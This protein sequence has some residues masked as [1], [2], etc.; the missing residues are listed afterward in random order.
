MTTVKA[1]IDLSKLNMSLEQWSRW[2]DTNNVR[3][4]KEASEWPNYIRDLTQGW[5]KI[6]T[7]QQYQAV[8]ASEITGD[9]PGLYAL[10]IDLGSQDLHPI[11]GNRTAYFG[12]TT[13]ALP[14]RLYQHVGALKGYRTNVFD[15]WNKYDKLVNQA[16][17]CDIKNQLSKTWI[18]FRPHAVTDKE[19]KWQ[20][21]HSQEMEKQALAHYHSLWGMFPPANTRD[22]P[23]SYLCEKVDAQ[24]SKTFKVTNR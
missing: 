19:H 15:K 1:T 14:K 5:K 23:S 2:A 22:I 12:E 17:K 20:R 7:V 24:L 3:W 9:E 13:Q 18:W 6:C 21:D 4:Y 11:L 8:L 16:Y 10:V